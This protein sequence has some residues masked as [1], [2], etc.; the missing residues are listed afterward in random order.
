MIAMGTRFALLR[1]NCFVVDSSKAT[2]YF[3]M[4]NWRH[5]LRELEG[6]IDELVIQNNRTEDN[7][8]R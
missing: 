6:V 5:P 8:H 4:K 2:L 7:R 1:L 3:P